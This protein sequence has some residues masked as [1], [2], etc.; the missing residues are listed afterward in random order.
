VCAQQQNEKRKRLG[1]IT[2]ISQPIRLFDR[3]TGEEEKTK[4]RKYPTGRL[5]KE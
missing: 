4:R 1:L 5:A 3:Q 2:N